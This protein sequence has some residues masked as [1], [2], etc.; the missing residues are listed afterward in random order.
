MTQYGGY[1]GVRRCDGSVFP[2]VDQCRTISYIANPVVPDGWCR[3]NETHEITPE[4]GDECCCPVF[5]QADQDGFAIDLVSVCY[6]AGGFPWVGVSWDVDPFDV[7]AG[8]L[9]CGI[10]TESP[11]AVDPAGMAGLLNRFD[12]YGTRWSVT[13]QGVCATVDIDTAA[14]YGDLCVDRGAGPEC[15]A[16]T[17]NP[18]LAYGHPAD[19]LNPAPWF[20]GSRASGEFFGFMLTDGPR[21]FT[22]SSGLDAELDAGCGRARPRVCRREISLKVSSVAATDRGARFGE[23]LLNRVFSNSCDAGCQGVDLIVSRFCPD[24]DSPAGDDDGTRL[25]RDVAYAGPVADVTPEGTPSCA[26]GDFDVALQAGDP[27]T[28]RDP[29]AVCA[30]ALPEV[31]DLS[32]PAAD[33]LPWRTP[34]QPDLEEFETTEARCVLNVDVHHDRRWCAVG[35]D[36]TDY[37]GVWPPVDGDGNQCQIVAT[38][39]EFDGADI[40]DTDTGD[41]C[42]FDV[43]FVINP[44]APAPANIQWEPINWDPADH[45][46]T[47]GIPCGC[48]IRV[49]QIVTPTEGDNPPKPW[50]YSDAPTGGECC[51]VILNPDGTIGQVPAPGQTA[52]PLDAVDLNGDL[53]IVTDSG[54]T[55]QVVTTCPA[56]DA[57]ELY[58]PTVCPE[59]DTCRARFNVDSSNGGV[60]SPLNF[61]HQP[62]DPFPDPA[63]DFVILGN[64][65]LS[66]LVTVTRTRRRA[67]APETRCNPPDGCGPVT[68]PLEPLPPLVECGWCEPVARWWECCVI[69]PGSCLGDRVL[70]VTVT[71]ADGWDARYNRVAVYPLLEDAPSPSTIEGREL[72]R[73]MLEPVAVAEINWIPAGAARTFDGVT[74]NVTLDC[75]GVCET[76]AA[77]VLGPA[78]TL[79]VNPAVP[80]AQGLVVCLIANPWAPPASMDVTV[81]ARELS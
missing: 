47:G 19:P 77:G 30:V 38:L 42:P 76:S 7:W 78:Q 39:V 27:Y 68:P 44:A 29:D 60:W 57:D 17:V 64:E 3:P 67:T 18:V 49:T 79:W 10:M 20:D 25:I 74:G 14:L 70:T 73:T 53:I 13:V 12:P 34:T 81:T 46:D 52:V 50:T 36:T 40:P 55:Y 62:T 11:E 15:A 8:D 75:G 43:R 72:Y 56:G 51:D 6:H 59:T 4:C 61:D 28:Y 80:S 48:E 31:I 33:C 1:V 24:P 69:D 37:G 35:W 2:L 41:C 5:D 66:D 71:A 26:G 63:C 21:S 45:A 32:G 9:S 16:P 58:P 54:C 65:N 23:E 22:I